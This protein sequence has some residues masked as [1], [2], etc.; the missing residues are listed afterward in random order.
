MANHGPSSQDKITT[1]KRFANPYYP[2]NQGI[3]GPGRKVYIEPAAQNLLNELNGYEMQVVCKQIQALATIT[4][5]LDGAQCKIHPSFSKIK[6][7]DEA[8]MAGNYL[9]KYDLS[10][11]GKIVIVAI[12]FNYRALGAQSP[13]KSEKNV[14]YRVRKTFN[15]RLTE[16]ISLNQIA[17]L[18]NIWDSGTPTH[19]ITTKHAA[20]NGMLND[21]KKATWLMGTHADV[22]FYEDDLVEYSLFHN[23]STGRGFPDLY[24]TTRDKTGFTTQ[25]AKHLAAV[26]FDNQQRGH[27]VKW[28]AHSQGAA[29]FSEAVRYHNRKVGTLLDKNGI[30]FH[31]GAHN[32]NITRKIL[33]IAGIK[34]LA[35]D[36]DNPFDMVPSQGG[37]N[38]WCW[39]T[40]KGSTRFS[41]RIMGE[42]K[43]LAVSPHTLPFISLDFYQRQLSA[44]GHTQLA[45]IVSKKINSLTLA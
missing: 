6:M 23:P 10:N 11:S 41:A 26:L 4:V 40:I 14:I 45:N 31:S 33:N 17:E 5:P 35:S 19:Q 36:R 43:T 18:P 15:L 44:G 20:V 28:V 27:E 9:I 24:E 42:N 25:N 30:V 12:G 13:V 1:A 38:D 32:K 22:A 8:A 34:I 37:F 16:N 29:I 2:S 39:G 3:Y 21:F 7:V